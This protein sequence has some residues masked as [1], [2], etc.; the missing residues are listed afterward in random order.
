MEN[1]IVITIITDILNMKAK[2]IQ[3]I[4]GFPEKEERIS[5]MKTICEDVIKENY[6][7]DIPEFATQT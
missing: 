3:H 4:I 2:K 7:R 5:K 6:F 1:N